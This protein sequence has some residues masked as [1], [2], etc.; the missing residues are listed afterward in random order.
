MTVTGEG[1]T[2]PHLHDYL[3]KARARLF[4]WVRPLSADQYARE[5]P[6]GLKTLRATMVE[7][8]SGEWV[9]TRRLSGEDMPPPED[10]PFTRF[11]HTGF[12]DLEPVWQ[13]ETER[14]AGA[15]REI[16]D[17]TAPVEYVVRPA[18]RPAIRVQTT[19][20]G[21]AAQLLFH[22]VHHRA[23]AMAMLRQLGIAAQNLDFSVFMFHRT[24][25][26]A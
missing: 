10:R 8:A 23:Q 21:I 24:D 12:A 2:P 25:L 13:R 9:Y 26:P 16:A 4:D 6:M 17:W 11:A 3:V 14:T 7:I 20:G 1:F 18:D 15:L 19:T 5:F 22:E